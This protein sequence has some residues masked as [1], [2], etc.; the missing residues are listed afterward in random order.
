MKSVFEGWFNICSQR[1]IKDV[2]VRMLLPSPPRLTPPRPTP[3][4]YNLR[5]QV[6]T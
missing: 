3:Y 2:V 1:G 6:I 5:Q 4:R